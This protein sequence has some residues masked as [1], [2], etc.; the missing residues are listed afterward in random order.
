MPI[1]SQTQTIPQPLQAAM[2]N[3]PA[4]FRPGRL[5]VGIEPDAP[6][7]NLTAALA[8]QGMTLERVY[9]ALHI[10]E[11]S[12]PTVQ[13][14]MLGPET[15]TV[16]QA[17][18][19]A[20][21]G[22]PGV[23]YVAL[24]ERVQI[25]QTG[26]PATAAATDPLS[27]QQ[28]ALAKVRARDSWKIARGSPTVPVAIIDTGY[29]IT[30]PDL[31]PE[32]LWVNAAEQNG[33]PGVDDDGNGYIDDIH[34][35]DW[36]GAGGIDGIDDNE[37]QDEQ[38]HGT[39]VFGIIAAAVDN[40]IGIAGLGPN[41]RAAPLRVL[42]ASGA[43]WVSDVIAALD[44][45]RAMG[46][47]VANLSLT[48]LSDSPPLADAVR[49]AYD[50]GMLVVAATGNNK[51][52]GGSVLWPA[53]YPEVLAVAATTDADLRADF[54]N[55]G[56]AVD[57]AAPGSEILSTYLG[58]DY[59]KLSGTSMAA[60]HAA[61]A[62]ALLWSLRPDL[63]ADQIVGLL[64]STAVDV[65]R[66]GLP[67]PD[68][69]LGAGRIDLAAAL[70]KASEALILADTG[71]SD[72][73]VL[74]NTSMV[75]TVTAAIQSGDSLLPAGEVVINYRLWDD[76]T[77][78]PI[79]TENQALTGADGTAELAFVTPPDDGFYRVRATAGAASVDIPLT[80]H[81]RPVSIT[82]TLSQAVVPVGE[83]PVQFRLELR[84]LEGELE[85]TPLPVRLETSL[86]SLLPSEISRSQ[87]IIVS[88]GVYTNS[89]YSGAISGA[90]LLRAAI[91]D[92]SIEVA[93]T[94]APG[95]PANILRPGGGPP[96]I[97]DA[98]NQLTLTFLIQ[99]QYG[100]AAADGIPIQFE[101]A[102][103]QLQPASATTSAGQA[104]TVLTLQNPAEDLVRVRVI[105]PDT[106]LEVVFEIPLARR[107]FLPAILTPE[108]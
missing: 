57:L 11:V 41:L 28:W 103:G 9:P 40:G 66:A 26:G 51:G 70:L 97:L 94:I 20:L 7:D 87:Q 77:N 80:V 49:A 58:G 67:G 31:P 71:Q 6:L 12:L 37:P 35:W 14:Q 76:A 27:G 59:R 2:D 32:R 75:I 15:A 22:L 45:A 86:G 24:D 23:R 95:P 62:A 1:R 88:G 73:L 3:T 68:S 21:M 82:L 63:G 33:R 85:P 64:K 101:S 55:T 8:A 78:A 47:R 48:V 56:D 36:V 60:P 52:T 39:H 104:K 44:Y 108:N 43:G 61:A 38:G 93:F 46:F 4:A 72:Y 34:G 83:K 100:N 102:D 79:G 25:A 92:A 18:Q 65:N 91:G 69:E 19:A 5:L 42:D 96:P 105:V 29:D 106:G 81:S 16:T 89:L 10:A 107:Y 17:A 99:D 54:S 98:T 13:A 30:H 53:A 84:T 74:P 90:A 50:A